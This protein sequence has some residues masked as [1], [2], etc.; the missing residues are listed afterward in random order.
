VSIGGPIVKQ[1]I[2]FANYE[3]DKRSDSGSNFVANDNGTTDVNESRVLATDLMHVS[4]ELGK[5]GY[6][7]YQGFTH[8]SDSNNC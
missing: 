1:I 8:N 3:I 2:L 5:L 4:T 6:N 7:A